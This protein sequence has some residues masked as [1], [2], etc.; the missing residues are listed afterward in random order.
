LVDTK[1]INPDETFLL[2][3]P[4]VSQRDIEVASC[5]NDAFL[6]RGY[7]NVDVRWVIW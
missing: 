3:I 1:S 7:A 6:E 5:R 2:L 4:K